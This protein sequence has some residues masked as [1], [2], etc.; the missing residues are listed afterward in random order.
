MS[1]HSGEYDPFRYTVLTKLSNYAHGRVQE[2][3]N[4]M[5]AGTMSAA[6]RDLIERGLDA[7]DA[8]QNE[9]GKELKYDPELSLAKTRAEA[10]K[11]ND[12]KRD[13]I[14]IALDDGVDDSFLKK[15]C[16]ELGFDLS[17]I[18]AL[19]TVQRNAIESKGRRIVR[20]N[21]GFWLRGFLQGSGG[22]NIAELVKQGEAWGFTRAQIQRTLP[23]I[24]K[25]QGNGKNISWILK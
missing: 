16:K 15:H 23:E 19:A 13:L 3:A 9:D 25:T 14:D 12:L 20:D 22:A 21:C 18:V 6:A 11:R 17:E 5:P 10:R 2:V 8:K 7:W 4:Q 24:A 1:D